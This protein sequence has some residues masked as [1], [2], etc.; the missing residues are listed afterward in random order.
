MRILP[1]AC[2][3]AFLVSACAAHQPPVPLVGPAS[4]IAAL[5][6]EWAGEYSSSETGRT[7]SISFVLAAHG[8]TAYGDVIMVPRGLS[9]PLEPWRDAVPTPTEPAA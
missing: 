7:G 6:G 4:D 3:F 1:R 8:D 2:A 5:V 9:Q